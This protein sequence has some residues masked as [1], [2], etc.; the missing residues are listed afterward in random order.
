MQDSSA[1]ASTTE[2]AQSLCAIYALQALHRAGDTP[3]TLDSTTLNKLDKAQSPILVA[4][5]QQTYLLTQPSIESAAGGVGG[6]E[7]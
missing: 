6:F 2:Q 5:L 4:T 1:I 7:A 3:T